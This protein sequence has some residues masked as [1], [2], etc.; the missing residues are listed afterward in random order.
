MSLKECFQSDT[1][2]QLMYHIYRNPQ[3]YTNYVSIMYLNHDRRVPGKLKWHKVITFSK[4]ISNTRLKPA[5]NQQTRKPSNQH[6]H[7]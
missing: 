7:I 2:L 4:V 1:E 5:K 6:Q 3:N